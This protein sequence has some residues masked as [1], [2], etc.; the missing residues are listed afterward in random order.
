MIKIAIAGV[1]NCASAL[2]Q[3]LS[4]SRKGAL[5]GLIRQ[6]VGRWG[7]ETSR[8]N[9]LVCGAGAQRGGTGALSSVAAGVKVMVF[10]T[11]GT[12]DW[13]AA[14]DFVRKFDYRPAAMIDTLALRRPIYRQTT[15]YGHFGKPQLSWEA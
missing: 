5:E 7:V 10:D 1:G 9:V 15:N 14:E 13:K 4:A 11:F 3:A 6:R 2:V 8:P 12:G